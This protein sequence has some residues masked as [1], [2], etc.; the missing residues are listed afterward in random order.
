MDT[1]RTLLM[2]T[3]QRI[4]ADHCHKPLLDEAERGE[5]PDAL[6]GLIRE[7]GFQQLAMARSGVELADALA[8]LEP[9]GR[10]A[11]PLPLAEMLLGNRWLE[12]DALLVSVGTG[13]A[14]GARDVPWGRRAEAVVAIRPEGGAVLLRDLE[15]V[16]AGRNLAGEPRDRVRG[17]KAEPLPCG[18]DA[19]ALLALT[20]AVLMSGGLSRALEMSIEYATER[21]QFGRPIARFQAIQ[22]HLA[23]MASHTAAAIRAADAGLAAIGSDGFAQ[24]VAVAK[25]RVGEAVGVVA[26]LAHQVH[27]AM[28]Y[29]YEHRLHHTTR[30][31]WS[32]RDEYGAEQHWQRRL[33]AHL[34][35][36][37]ARDGGDGLWAFIT[38]TG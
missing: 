27:G 23:V 13:D 4:F 35:K 15:V 32:W 7:S 8:V 38:G 29:T 19:W 36:R 5:F 24:E 25:A 11:L 17:G 20:R 26:E 3:A 1:T 2:D 6:L 37:V 30:R 22:H 34:A 14:A 28:G 16:Q 10:H 33:G 21:E 31:L 18:E 9:A 12:D